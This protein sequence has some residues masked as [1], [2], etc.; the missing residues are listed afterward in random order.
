MAVGPPLA[1]NQPGSS[2]I[3]ARC[4]GVAKTFGTGDSAVSALRG[5]D[6]DVND[7][8]LLLLAGPSGCGKT[9]LLSILGVLLER[10]SGQCDVLGSDPQDMR[11]DERARFRGR[12][13]GFVYQSFNLLPALSAEENVAV[14][15]LICGTARRVALS[16]AKEMLEIVGLGDRLDAMP[17]QL[18]GGAQQRVGIARALIREPRLVI[19]DEP[20]SNLDHETGARM[21][22]LLR[23]A[24]REAGRAVVVATHDTRMFE[25]ADR[26]ARMEDGRVTEVAGVAPRPST[27]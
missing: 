18:S 1:L 14:P 19:C 15:L 7:G 25:Y 21:M 17:V 24:G 3:I 12:S 11:R 13:L 16:R 27:Q 22:H 20:T 6:L 8:E 2:Q 9:T 10:D 23:R 5:V 4:R 26:I